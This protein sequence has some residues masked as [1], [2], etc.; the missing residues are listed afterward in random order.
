MNLN[1]KATNL[2]VTPDIR[3]YLE[4]RLAS[5]GRL[6][7][8]DSPNTAIQVELGKETHHQHGEVYRAEIKMNRGVQ[9]VYVS[10]EGQN[11]QEAIDK[12]KDELSREVKSFKEKH[13]SLVRRGASKVKS[14]LRLGKGDEPS[15]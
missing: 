2:Q 13:R 11:I 10:A 6:V 8:F 3:A 15:E 9:Q 7:D 14:F 4:K 12:V 1:I 5:L